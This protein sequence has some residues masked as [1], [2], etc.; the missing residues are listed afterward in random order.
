MS[1]SPMHESL[2]RTVNRCLLQNTAVDPSNGPTGANKL[3]DTRFV[4]ALYTQG[5]KGHWLSLL[6]EN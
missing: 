5:T 3:A 2:V 6:E 4:L 1:S